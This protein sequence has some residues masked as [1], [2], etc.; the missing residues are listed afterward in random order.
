MRIL[1]ATDGSEC[2]CQAAR[3]FRHLAR[4]IAYQIHILHV[5]PLPTVGVATTYIRAEL[6]QDGLAAMYAVRSILE[7]CSSTIGMEL[8]EGVP[9]DAI[10]QAAEEREVDLIVLGHHGRDNSEGRIL[11]STARDVVQNAPCTVLVGM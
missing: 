3:R 1:I 4:P 11:G 9:A 7:C 6:E 2:S 10:V 5:L 8:R